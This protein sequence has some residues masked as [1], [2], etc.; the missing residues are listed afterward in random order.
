MLNVTISTEPTGPSVKIHYSDQDT[1]KTKRT[2]VR[3][4]GTAPRGINPPA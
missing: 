4:F 3:F 2:S 1:D